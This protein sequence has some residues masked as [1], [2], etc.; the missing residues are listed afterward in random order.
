M[1]RRH[2]P[3][4][5]MPDLL[6]DM[7]AGIAGDMLLGALLDLGGD[8][9]ALER[10]LLRLGVGPI[11]IQAEPVLVN[12]IRAL[13]VDV[14]ADQEPTWTQ[15]AQVGPL[16]VIGAA[17]STA[18]G[19]TAQTHH[20]HRPYAE[21]RAVIDRADLP[22]GAKA[23]AQRVFRILAE[24]EGAVHGVPPDEVGFHEVGSLDAIADVVGTC[25]LLDQLGVRRIL[26]GPILPG[27]GSVRCA[28]GRM[29]VPVPA[30]AAMLA[31]HR[32]PQRRSG[33]ETGEL[34]TPTGCAL[35]LGL[36]DAFLD[37]EVNLRSTA[38]GHG[39]GHKRFT[40][41]TNILRLHLLEEGR[42]DDTVVELRACIDDASGEDLALACEALLADGARDAWL[43]PILMKKGRPGHELVVLAAPADAERLGDRIFVLTP[44][45]GL[46]QRVF[47]RRILPRRQEVVVVDGESIPLK[48]VTLPDGSERAKPED[49]AVAAVARR[50]GRPPAE[51][52]RAALA[53]WRL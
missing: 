18:T 29:P 14:A 5:P 31:A 25:L 30:V 1:G 19:T 8:R 15:P 9:Q 23:R 11:R 33:G 37:G 38:I 46:R 17:A 21:V 42:E 50:L 35:V 45:I 3:S 6:I 16:K 39:A 24:A 49:D 22:A 32:A 44:T 52:R 12:G 10:D 53:A 41:R 13:Q 2:R 48:I 7:P 28:H 47:A 43:H 26:A 20:P 36:A 4:D 34:T 40:D 51:I 27:E